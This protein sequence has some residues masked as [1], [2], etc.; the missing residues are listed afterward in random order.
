MCGTATAVGI[1]FN[2]DSAGVHQ[3]LAHTRTVAHS[4]ISRTLVCIDLRRHTTWQDIN[5]A[6]HLNFTFICNLLVWVSSVP[7]DQ[8]NQTMTQTHK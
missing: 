5:I 2:P 4:D 3:D 1:F 7:N 8:G 6:Q